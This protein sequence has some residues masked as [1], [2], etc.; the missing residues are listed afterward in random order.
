MA[1][2]ERRRFG[3]CRQSAAATALSRAQD[4]SELTRTFVRTKSGVAL[5]FEK[6]GGD[7]HP[8]LQPNFSTVPYWCGAIVLCGGANSFYPGEQG[9][10]KRAGAR[11]GSVDEG[12]NRGTRGACAPPAKSAGQ[13]F[14]GV[15]F[16]RPCFNL[17]SM[18]ASENT[19][20]QA[21]QQTKSMGR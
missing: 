19:V 16:W 15:S 12:V 1:E 21:Q 11:R 5:G 13:G 6:I 8:D 17:L 18:Q 14:H 9:K 3:L 2:A 4:D 7:E 20:N 10:V